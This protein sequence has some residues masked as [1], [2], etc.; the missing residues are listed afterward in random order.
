MLFRAY[1]T[2]FCGLEIYWY[3]MEL[4]VDDAIETQIQVRGTPMSVRCACMSVI[5]NRSATGG[6]PM[7]SRP[8]LIRG[9]RA[10]QQYQY[11]HPEVS[12]VSISQDVVRAEG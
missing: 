10:T 3:W 5:S 1:G 2:T 7:K 9:R 6:S 11:R 8:H 4:A 12:S